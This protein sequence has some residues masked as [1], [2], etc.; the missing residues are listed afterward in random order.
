M[1]SC[2]L[3][4]RTEVAFGLEANGTLLGCTFSAGKLRNVKPSPVKGVSA[5][6]G[7]IKEGEAGDPGGGSKAPGSSAKLD[8]AP[9]P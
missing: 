6:P 7:E 2:M 1:L 9:L 5:R 4:L 3:H 8:G